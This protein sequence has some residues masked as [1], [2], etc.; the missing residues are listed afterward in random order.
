MGGK[1]SPRAP[2]Y[3]G[4][5]AESAEASQEL[6]TQNTWANRPD[7]A[8]P[9]GTSTW[10]AAAGVDP[11]TGQAITNWTQNIELGADQQAALDSQ[12]AVQSGRSQLAQGLI[13]RAGE[14]LGSPMDWNGMPPPASAPDVPDFYGQGLGQM[15]ELPDPNAASQNNFDFEGNY[16][17]M[18]DYGQGPQLQGY[19][20]TGVTRSAGKQPQYD[21]ESIAR[22]TDGPARYSAR[23]VQSE[24]NSNPSY[25]AEKI[26]RGTEGPSEYST[27][28][29]QRNVEANPSYNSENVQRGLDFSGAGDVNSGG[30]YQDRFGQEQYERQMSLIGPQQQQATEGLEV[31]LRNQGLN[32]GDEAYD[33]ALKDMRDQQG[34]ANGRMSADAVRFGA[35][36]QQAQ[37]GREM[38]ARQQGVGEV[39]QQGRF[40]NQ[41]SQQALEQQFGMGDREYAQSLGSGQFANQAAQQA[42]NQ[43]N[44]AGGQQFDQSLQQG[45]FA[46][47]AAQQSQNQQ[48]AMGGQQFSQDLQA[49]QFANQ[50]TQQ[51][52]EQQY[53]I[54]DRGFNQSMQQNQFA[55]QAA[56][57]SADQQLAMGGQAWNQQMQGADLYNQSGQQQFNQNL[58]AGGQ[59][60]NEQMGQ[61]NFQNQQR[62]QQ[63]QELQALQGQYGQQG[64]QAYRRQMDTAQYQDRQRAQQVQEQ[65]AMGGQGFSQQMQQ[66]N[67]QNAL[68]QQGISEEQMRRGTSIN[69]MNALQTGQQVGMPGMPSFMGATMGQSADY[70][71]AAQMQGNF[72]QQGYSTAMGPVNAL[73][74]AAGTA[75]GGWAGGI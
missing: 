31:Q 73:I 75:A 53:D 21:A 26:Q 39:E 2:D 15:G 46:N 16:N 68:R 71:G 51:S 38:S 29:V 69:E 20:Q 49:G 57:Q 50:A 27:E 64:E 72:A 10:D 34:E 6:A 40:A 12:M 36:R 7:Q 43:S 56:Q 41:A 37:F 28:S 5:A 11:S 24:V 35:D 14:E 67:Y 3:R 66:A 58:A 18:Q 62:A 19:G 65:L 1:S 60:F 4:A 33:R 44:F 52:M 22:S 13:E 32:P 47:E 9:W 42:Q 48:L 74:G 61:G 54:G 70:L 55:N 17:R 59:R 45:R 25:T 63:F 8:T 23:D 30:G